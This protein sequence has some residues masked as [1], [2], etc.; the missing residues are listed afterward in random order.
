M[1]LNRVFLAGL[2][3]FCLSMAVYI[4]TL[5]P[6]FH[7]N[8][9]PETAACAYT[10]GIQHPP[11]Y[12]LAAL[13]GR[14]FTF[15]PVGSPGF[16]VNL[17]AAFFGSLTCV[18][19]FLILLAV[20]KNPG[21]D[22]PAPLVAAFAA[23]L[24][25]AFSPT[26]WAEAL[27]SKGG[28]YTLNAF[29]LMAVIWQVFEW[30]RTKKI[31]YMYLAAFTY[32][33]SLSNHW[34]SMAVAGPALALFVILGLNRDGFYRRITPKNIAF[35]AGFL[36]LGMTVYAYLLIRSKTAILN[37]GRPGTF[38][39]LLQVILREQYADLEKARSISTVASQVK[40]AA[41]LLL[42]EFSPAG[43]LAALAGAALM[44]LK[45]R[46]ERA[47]FFLALAGTILAALS[48]YFNLKEEMLW[49]MDV[50]M[51]P[52]YAVMAVFIGAVIKAVLDLL[53]SG[54]RSPESGVNYKAGYA[55][56]VILPFLTLGANYGRSD[57]SR[58]FYAYD[59]GMN[60][61]KSIEPPA[62]ALLDGDFN[63][64]PQMY[65]RY[66]DKKTGFC[67]VTSIF[68]YKPWGVINQRIECP[69]VKFTSA[70]NDSFSSKLENIVS[71][72]FRDMGI[73]T[74]VFRKSIEEFYPALN[75]V[76]APNGLAMKL[77]F[78][79]KAALKD[80]EA[81]LKKLSYRGL[82]ENKSYQNSTTMLCVSNYS[83]AYM[84]A[85]NAFKDAVELK[86]AFYYM[87][88]A[89]MLANK[90]TK[91]QSYTHLG[92]LYSTAGDNESAIAQYKKAVEADRNLPEPYSN[93]AG[94]MNGKGDY[95]AAIKYSLEAIRLKPKFSEAYNNLAIA[96][97]NKG[98]MA[99]AIMNMEKAVEYNPS[100]ELAR[101]NLGI[102]KGEIK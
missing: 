48:F 59:F 2:A 75:K 6:V 92:I 33:L 71:L 57:Q 9:S 51:V 19:L 86:K 41:L 50:F 31:K 23:S 87:N 99:N 58:Y 102:M 64:M 97:Y 82:L 28:I 68:L 39:Q 94:L 12:P 52:V 66:V 21:E 83:S 72:N 44:L 76:L 36:V 3:V 91:A 16:R 88:R 65:F 55:A 60:I 27:S 18:M 29:F 85:G 101:R 73:Y 20:L 15:L 7:A 95:D 34:E 56:A 5:N 25:F 53:K 4:I 67:P 49:I 54:I 79:R 70:L 13:A 63:V 90:K 61:I 22:G 46:R 40:N 37:W 38:A 93:L 78:D 98:D 69:D 45:K 62:I 8:D 11:G 74:S 10:L 96:Y 24:L 42:N 17:K 84:E 80:A 1:S 32:G 77:V 35:C 26:F 81:G 30:E 47:V 100:N 89:V 43:L 14:I